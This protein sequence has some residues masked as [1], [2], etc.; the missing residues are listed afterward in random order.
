MRGTGSNFAPF[1][2]VTECF[3]SAFTCK[4]EELKFEIRIIDGVY[5]IN[6]EQEL[7]SKW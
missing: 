4:V 1:G 2:I 5:F 3:Y 7:E 6:I